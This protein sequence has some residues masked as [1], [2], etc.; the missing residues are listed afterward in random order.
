MV[1]LFQNQTV[2]WLSVKLT[3]YKYKEAIRAG[4]FD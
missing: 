2:E 3:A 4:S 1:Q